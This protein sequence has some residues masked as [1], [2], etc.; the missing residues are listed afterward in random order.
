MDT[1]IRKAE[2]HEIELLSEIAMKSKAHWGY[3]TE[4][5]ERCRSE[6]TVTPEKFNS[7][8]FT[9]MVCE[10][11]DEILGFYAIGTLGDNECELD[12]LF[13]KPQS[14]GTGVGK[15]LIEH[16]IALVARLGFDTLTIHSDPNTERFYLNAGAILIG[17][18]ESNS[19]EGRYLPV[20]SI[21]LGAAQGPS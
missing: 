2:Q 20:L 19:I 16:A 3:S 17:T 9:H 1:E 15:A 21:P 11:D 7:V 6:L 4:F 18:E 10:S 13:V 12:A 5:M 8:R 14:I